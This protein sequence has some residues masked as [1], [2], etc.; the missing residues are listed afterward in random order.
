[1]NHGMNHALGA[2]MAQEGFRGA[3]DWASSFSSS[4]YREASLR[5]DTDGADGSDAVPPLL[6]LQDAHDDAA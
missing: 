6:A 5:L 1:M 2:R 3:F 4:S